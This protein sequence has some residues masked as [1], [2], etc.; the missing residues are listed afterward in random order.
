[1]LPRVTPRELA[2][3]TQAIGTWD[4]APEG[5]E[6]VVHL[7][8]GVSHRARRAEGREALMREPGTW[9]RFEALVLALLARVDPSD[10]DGRRWFLRLS[11]VR[12]SIAAAPRAR[13]T[14]RAS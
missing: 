5:F 2:S 12:D 9:M 1:M 13:T 10:P 3:V 6:R 4:G 11:A 14:R 7:V 8:E